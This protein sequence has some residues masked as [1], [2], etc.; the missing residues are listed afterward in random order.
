MKSHISGNL[1]RVGLML[2]SSESWYLTHANIYQKCLYSDLEDIAFWGWVKFL[3]KNR[4]VLQFHYDQGTKATRVCKKNSAIYDK[5]ALS[6]EP[7]QKEFCRFR[8]ENFHVK[9][10]SRGGWKTAIELLRK[11][12]QG[13][14]VSSYDLN[15]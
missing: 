6:E 7:A 3:K 9:D 10:A 12:E 11:F 5:N 8:S 2:L 1:G 4:Y 13:R 14:H 15:I